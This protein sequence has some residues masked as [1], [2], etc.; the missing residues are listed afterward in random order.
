MDFCGYLTPL[1]LD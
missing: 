1:D